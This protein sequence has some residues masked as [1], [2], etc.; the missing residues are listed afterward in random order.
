MRK[1]DE[2]PAGTAAFT[3]RRFLALG[4]LASAGLV[5]APGI[6]H[7]IGKK[8]GNILY[9]SDFVPEGALLKLAFV[10]DHHYWPD[11]FKNWGEKQFRDT[12]PRMRD[13]VGM[14][15]REKPDLSVHCGDVISAGNSFVPPPEEYIRQLDFEKTFLDS[16]HHPAVPVIGNH[17]VP[18]DEYTHESELD[19]WKKR[20]GPLHRM[21]DIGSRRL[22]F[23]NIMVPNPG[24]KLGK[25]QVYGIDDGQVR[26]LEGVLKEAAA[27]SM[28]ALLF[29]HVPPEGFSWKNDFEKVVVS[30]GCVGGIFCGHT[31]RNSRGT[32]GDIPV[33]VR[34]SNTATPMGYSLIYPYPDGR[35]LVVQKSQHF[36]FI[37]YLSDSIHPDAQG[38][39]D[40]RYFTLGGSTELPLDGLK[41]VGESAAAT[42][43]DGHLTL[44]SEKGRGYLLIDTSSLDG[45][46]IRF[47]AVKEK[48]VRMGVFAGASPDCS[49]RVEGVVTSEYGPDG[50]LYLASCSGAEQKTLDRSWFNISDGIAYEFTLEIRKG[51]AT[52]SM[53]NMP[54][55]KASLEKSTAGQFGLFVENGAMIVTDLSLERA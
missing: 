50:N 21:V 33:V 27:K 39:E 14:L 16:L 47:S 5:S 40:D 36:P 51:K 31:H 24:R 7:G 29:F 32:L 41:V 2:H 44:Q 6:T 9:S 55:L 43:R 17:E 45:G 12:G 11:H 25:G 22:V 26:W 42:I 38:G 46:R 28:T 20:F 52:L 13:L 54:G 34:A 49:R 19:E 18:D 4:A 23:L 37:N 1:N 35:L 48:A 15:N 53:K 30:S 10:A 3:R 8:S